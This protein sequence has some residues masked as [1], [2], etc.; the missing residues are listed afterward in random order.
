MD[1]WMNGLIFNCT[2]NWY[3]PASVPLFV[4]L[5]VCLLWKLPAEMMILVQPTVT[6]DSSLLQQKDLFRDSHKS[7]RF[8]QTLSFTSRQ[9]ANY[10]PLITLLIN[11][12]PAPHPTLHT[13]GWKIGCLSNASQVCAC[14][15]G[16]GEEGRRVSGFLP[17]ARRDINIIMYLLSYFLTLKSQECLWNGAKW[18][19]I[20]YSL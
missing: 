5:W 3:Q 4:S 12:T 18:L 10:T 7:I 15:S 2:E 16:G 13:Q 17:A 19:R 1:G 6:D 9:G 14:C 20:K 11:I 8:Y